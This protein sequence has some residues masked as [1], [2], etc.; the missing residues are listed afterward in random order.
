[1]STLNPADRLSDDEL[2]A[3]HADIQKTMPPN[4]RAVFHETE[5][6]GETA[7]HENFSIRVEPVW[8]GPGEPS[9]E[10]YDELHMAA[11]SHGGGFYHSR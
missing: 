9:E 5:C 4:W 7:T 11:V 10:D 1:M 2:A 3:I 6:T 8:A